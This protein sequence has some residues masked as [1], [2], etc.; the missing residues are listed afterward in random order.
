MQNILV[1]ASWR[2]AHIW[3]GHLKVA[4]EQYA[5]ASKNAWH[6]QS[7]Y[8]AGALPSAD[9]NYALQQALRAEHNARAKYMTVL[10]IYTH[11]LVHGELPKNPNANQV[12]PDEWDSV[13]SELSDESLE[14]RLCH[15]F[16]LSTL[17]PNIYQSRL[18]LLVAEV[19][20]R[21]KPEIVEKIKA[22]VTK[23]GT[24]PAH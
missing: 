8:K 14:Q 6:I 3:R 13:W 23:Y 10:E 15:Y 11:V 5:S 19:E 17:A 16:W 7:E 21:G 24:P 2:L 9:G 18:A 1:S 20:R 4:A 22:W 12:L